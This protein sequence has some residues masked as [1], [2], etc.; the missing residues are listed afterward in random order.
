LAQ[1]RY[2]MQAPIN[3]VMVVVFHKIQG[4]AWLA[5]KLLPSQ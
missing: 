2:K 5:E 4:M 1:D 3:L